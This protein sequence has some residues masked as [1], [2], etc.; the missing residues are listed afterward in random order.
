MQ[1]LITFLSAIV[2][3]NSSQIFAWV[4]PP[5][6]YPLYK[7]HSCHLPGIPYSTLQAGRDSKRNIT[8]SRK[9]NQCFIDL[10]D[11]ITSKALCR[12]VNHGPVTNSLSCSEP[13]RRLYESTSHINSTRLSNSLSISLSTSS[14]AFQTCYW[15]LLLHTLLTTILVLR[16]RKI[17]Y[18]SL[19]LPII[20]RYIKVNSI[21]GLEFTFKYDFVFI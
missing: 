17:I 6:G 1:E 14:R 10:I 7:L 13:I 21:F 2:L 9:C 4:L 8:L 12:S 16:P 20:L 3:I 18:P 19:T 5:I 11:V 15:K